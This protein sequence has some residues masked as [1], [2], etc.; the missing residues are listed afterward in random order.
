MQN[1]LLNVPVHDF[2]ELV[3]DRRSSK[4]VITE[5]RDNSGQSRQREYYD[6]DPEPRGTYREPTYY[7]PEPS[8]R[9]QTYYEPEPTYRE[10]TYYEPE[11]YR[12]P[13]YTR[14]PEG[15]PDYEPEPIREP[16]PVV[17]NAPSFD[18]ELSKGRN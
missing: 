9:E 5:V 14:K 8:Y 3:V 6:E 11:P 12:E 15:V 18:D 13:D 1:A 2:D 7:E 16:E 4:N 10:P 17:D